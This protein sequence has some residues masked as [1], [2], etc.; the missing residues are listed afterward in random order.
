MLGFALNILRA[1]L[2]RKLPKS[3]KDAHR[4]TQINSAVEHGLEDKLGPPNWSALS[5][6]PVTASKPP[7]IISESTAHSAPFDH[8]HT[9][10]TSTSGSG[11]V[12]VICQ[13]RAKMLTTFQFPLLSKLRHF[14][15]RTCD[16]AQVF[17]P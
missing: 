11:T 13:F 1:L 7:F 10:G 5:L 6:V 14:S 17:P 12:I 4:A 15:M 16:K 9:S 8:L 3:R 2:K